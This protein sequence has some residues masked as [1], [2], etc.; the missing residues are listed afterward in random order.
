VD[1]LLTLFQIFEFWNQD[2]WQPALE[3]LVASI[4]KKFSAAFDRQSL[5]R[6]IIDFMLIA[7]LGIGCA[8]EI[9]IS[10]HDDYDKWAI[11]ILVKFR[12]K[13]KLQLLTGQRQSGGVSM[14]QTYYVHGIYFE[15]FRNVR[16]PLSC[17]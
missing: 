8:G 1:F 5:H 2:R 3:K 6:G 16:S 11:D 4:G 7:S 13:E 12:D 15:G 10:P 9:R 17:T 14:D